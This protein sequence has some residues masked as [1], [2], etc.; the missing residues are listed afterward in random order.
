MNP[1][2]LVPCLDRLLTALSPTPVE[3]SARDA[4]KTWVELV[5]LW[6]R[7]LDLTAAR[8]PEEL[9][10]LLVA[11]ALQ[12]S[13]SARSETSWVDVGT[14]CGAPGLGLALLRPDLK[15]TLV[16][17]LE[18]R[19]SFLRTVIGTLR[20]T[21]IKIVRG[22]GEDTVAS[23]STFDVALSRATL[24]PVDWLALGHELAPAGDVIV[25][26][27]RVET[28]SH[29]DRVLEGEHAYTWP[30]TKAERRIATFSRRAATG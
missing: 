7:K 14:G 3:A 27:A 22:K 24:A 17:P 12:L 5:E 21:D 26:L 25:L 18:K 16:E 9:V 29:A 6:N 20:R 11:D 8:T 4:L 28:P 15:M 1:A 19:V 2:Q 23:G 10:D 13:L 30:L